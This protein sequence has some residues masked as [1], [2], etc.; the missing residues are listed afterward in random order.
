[1]ILNPKIRTLPNE[2]IR[3]LWRHVIVC[4]AGPVGQEI[5]GKPFPGWSRSLEPVEAVRFEESGHAVSML[6]CGFRAK[7]VN[8]IVHP[9]GVSGCASFSDRPAATYEEIEET[10]NDGVQAGQILREL[11]RRGHH[12]DLS[13]AI[14]TTRR[15]LKKHWPRVCCLATA[16]R[17][18]GD[19]LGEQAILQATGLPQPDFDLDAI[20]ET[21]NANT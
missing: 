10:P 20:E 8:V 19:V 18:H 3:Y 21:V 9:G 2:T 5:A 13:R 6:L 14:S 12:A 7:T 4:A 11:K 1:M 15:L 16:L 17:Q